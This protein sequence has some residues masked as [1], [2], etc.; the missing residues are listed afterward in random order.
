MAVNVEIKAK[1]SENTSNLIRRFSRKV[2][3]AGIIP[4]MKS[5]KF[6]SRPLSKNVRKKQ[7][8]RSLEKSEKVVHLI[9]LGKLPDRRRG[10]FTPHTSR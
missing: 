8:V 5:L 6:H 9:K 2:N 1:A 10:S 7:R 3:S 4:R